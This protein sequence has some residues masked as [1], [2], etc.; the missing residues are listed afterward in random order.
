MRMAISLRLAAIDEA[1]DRILSAHVVRAQKAPQGGLPGPIPRRIVQQELLVDGVLQIPHQGVPLGA[2]PP[3][4]GV[5]PVLA[6]RGARDEVLLLVHAFA[7]PAMERIPLHITAAQLRVV[8]S[9]VLTQQNAV[10]GIRLAAGRTVQ[11]AQHLGLHR[12]DR[13]QLDP[14]DLKEH[15]DQAVL[16]RLVDHGHRLALAQRVDALQPPG[17]AGGGVVKLSLVQHP[18]GGV[19]QDGGV[20]FSGPIDGTIHWHND[21]LGFRVAPMR[22]CLR[23]KPYPG[24]SQR[25]CLI[26]GC[27][28]STWRRPAEV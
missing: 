16:G 25:D 23:P 2:E 13:E 18:S 6:G 4:Q 21:L 19:L 26:G 9:Q 7:Q 5:Q 27:R 14:G 1:P 22:F 15:V 8:E 20:F 11:L 28:G 3:D 24:R 12:G 10:H 17:N